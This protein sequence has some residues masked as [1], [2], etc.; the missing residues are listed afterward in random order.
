MYPTSSLRQSSVIFLAYCTFELISKMIHKD[1][2]LTQ[3]YELVESMEES[4][5]VERCENPRSGPHRQNTQCIMHYA[6]VV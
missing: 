3:T 4:R 5:L 6:R 2:K 1:G